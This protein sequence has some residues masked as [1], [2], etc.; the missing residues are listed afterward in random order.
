MRLEDCFFLGSITRKH[1]TNGGLVLKLETD[2][3]ENYHHLESVL[4]LIEDEL[5]PFFL[6]DV[7]ILKPDTLRVFFEEVSPRESQ[8]YLGVEA[9]L[10]L[11]ILPKLSGKQFYFHEIEGFEAHDSEKGPIGQISHVMERP[12]QPLI[13]V[14]FGDKDIYIPAVDEIIVKI[15]RE[16][17]VMYFQCPTGLIDLYL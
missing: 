6:N 7:A 14:S 5:V 9:Y 16:Q 13:V 12:E 17:K 15:D 1:G 10:P 2:Q 4:L 11:T 8:D 3:P